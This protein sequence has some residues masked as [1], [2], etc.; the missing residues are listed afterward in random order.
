MGQDPPPA[1]EETGPEWWGN[2]VLQADITQHCPVGVWFGW[3]ISQPCCRHST[4]QLNLSGSHGRA[5][6]PPPS[7]P[8]T[9]DKSHSAGC[10]H[11]P[12]PL[13]SPTEP[14]RCQALWLPRGAGVASHTHPSAWK[15]ADILFPSQHLPLA[16]LL[17]YVL[18]L[19]DLDQ[20]STVH[21]H[22]LR[23]TYV[24]PVLQIT[25][26]GSEGLRNTLV[27]PPL[28]SICVGPGNES[29]KVWNPC[30]SQFHVVT[31]GQPL[32]PLP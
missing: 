16:C 4:T 30:S 25:D 32:Q 18:F 19:E 26:R 22:T 13:S 8:P 27:V 21:S 28:V 29:I 1:N 2:R 24:I 17:P 10:L 20:N 12:L 11:S 3:G 5:V 7:S 15:R 9:G 31:L 14:I 6:Q 23:T